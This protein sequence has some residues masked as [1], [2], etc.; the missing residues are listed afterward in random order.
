LDS[1]WLVDVPLYAIAVLLAGVRP[2]LLHL[3]PTLVA[4]V[5][6]CTGAWI[7]RFG[8]R[9][10]AA[11]LAGGAVLVLLGLPTRELAANFLMGPLHVTTVLWC[12]MAFVALRRGRYGW[13]WLLA[14]GFLAVGMLGDLQAAA[15]GVVPVFLAGIVRSLRTRSWRAG[16]PAVTAALGSVAA[17][18]A[19]R[20]LTLAIGTFS[21]AGMNPRASLHQMTFNLRGLMGYGASLGGVAIRPFSSVPRPS[22]LQ[23]THAIGLA[24]VAVAVLLAAVSALRSSVDGLRT[25]ATRL[26]APSSGE[27]PRAEVAQ[28]APG[29]GGTWFEDVLLF[30]FLGACATYVSL[31]LVSS[32]VYDRYLTSV[33]IFGSI[34]AARLVGGVAE[35]MGTARMRAALVAA[36]SLVATGYVASFAGSLTTPLPVQASTALV[37][38]LETNHLTLGIGDY[39]TSSI[40]TVESSDAVRVRPVTTDPGTGYLRRYNRQMTSAW[41]GGGFQFFVYNTALPWQSVDARSAAASFGPPLH[42][43][44]VSTYRVLTWGHDL[45]VPVNGEYVRYASPSSAACPQQTCVS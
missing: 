18:E 38:Y 8:R 10:W 6:I 29:A 14:L 44:S 45:S 30:G 24:V 15:L 25:A 23:V 41:Y 36:A 40:A 39:W 12:L 11:V 3:V 37:S 26:W 34:L 31:T 19:A 9:G 28:L 4:L 20:Y 13:S 5:V 35:R 32:N 2:Q 43:T 7:A 22:I 27:G 16:A 17:A 1:F 33:V 42:V 21:V